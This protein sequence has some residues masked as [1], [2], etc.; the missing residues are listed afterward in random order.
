MRKKTHAEPVLMLGADLIAREDKFKAMY[1]NSVQDNKLPAQSF[2]ESLKKR[3]A[4]NCPEE[5]LTL[6]ARDG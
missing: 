4:D 5:S 6:Q 3:L 1:G 2:C